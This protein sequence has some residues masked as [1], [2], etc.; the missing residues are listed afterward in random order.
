MKR[1][2]CCVCVVNIQWHHLLARDDNRYLCILQMHLQLLVNNKRIY[3][4][5]S[6]WLGAMDSPC[7]GSL[8][9]FPVSSRV[10]AWWD[11]LPHSRGAVRIIYH[12]ALSRSKEK[13]FPKQ[14]FLDTTIAN[15]SPC[16]LYYL[17]KVKELWSK[18]ISAQFLDWSQPQER[19]RPCMSARSWPWNEQE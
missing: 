3:E 18:E 19:R 6:W 17:G 14:L 16:R 7:A 11:C 1:L 12:T 9:S 4:F 5:H 2:L 15:P 8:C 10:T 13:D